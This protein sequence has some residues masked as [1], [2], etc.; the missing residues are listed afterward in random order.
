M[1]ITNPSEL[2]R[3]YSSHRI[4][5]GIPGV[6]R[7]KSGRIFVSFYS[8]GTKEENGNFALVVRSD[9][10]E[11][12]SEPIAAAFKE[13]AFRCYD[14][15]L[16]I[17]PLDRLWFFWGVMPGAE[18]M[19]TIC[20]DPDA[21]ELVWSEE[22]YV[23]RGV[24]MNKPTVLSDGRW[25][26][27]IALWDPAVC[28]TLPFGTLSDCDKS[29]AFVYESCDQGKTFTRLGGVAI[30]DRSFDEHMIVEQK[31]GSLRMLVRLMHGIGESYS[32]DGGQ[33]WSEGFVSELTGPSS[34]FFIRR[35][36]S[37]RILFINH[38]DF[39]GRNNL[40][41]ML[42]ED[43]G[44]TFP[45]RLLLDERNFVTYPDAFENEDG[46]IDIVY[47]HE[48]GALFKSM[49][50]VYTQAREIL[51]AKIT[52]E[53]ILHGALVS[54]GSYLKHVVSRLGRLDAQDGDPF[55]AS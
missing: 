17:D 13:G 22:F 11:S 9:D 40:T 39:N 14:P 25:L 26:F 36:R 48:R 5:Q 37:G 47:D 31:D 52:E 35:L 53:D 49:E 28:P 12:F 21:D 18:V 19:A 27:P 24:M 30:P 10:G 45:Y 46:T 6:V 16:W 42:S 15:V 34:R 29:A 38:Y 55:A 4:W 3:F 8:G 23:G 54:E 32:Y 44:K 43:D 50:Q 33:S 2:S 7:T 1:L 51:H 41:A 20:D